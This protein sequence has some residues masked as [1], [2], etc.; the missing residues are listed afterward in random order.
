MLFGI[1]FM[2]FVLISFRLFKLTICISKFFVIERFS[3]RVSRVCGSFQLTLK[4]NVIEQI[5]VGGVV[6]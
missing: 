1:S 6:S 4:R 2:R 5:Y 3:F